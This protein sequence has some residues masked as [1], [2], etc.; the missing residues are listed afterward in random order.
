[1]HKYIFIS[2]ILSADLFMTGPANAIDGDFGSPYAPGQQ[3]N[4]VTRGPGE[5]PVYG[6]KS[7]GLPLATI[8]GAVLVV[9]GA[10]AASYW[11]IQ[12]IRRRQDS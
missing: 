8:I 10:G 2:L 6:G 1:M 7:T 9:L 3:G 11:Q 12:L 4:V 5:E